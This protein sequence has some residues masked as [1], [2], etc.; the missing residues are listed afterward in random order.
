[1]R[2]VPVIDAGA[3][4]AQGDCAEIAP[5]IFEVGEVTVRVVGEGDPELLLAAAEACPTGAIMVI[6]A[7]SGDQVFP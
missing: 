1:M 6:D 4:I 5:E 7:D 3:C 2:C